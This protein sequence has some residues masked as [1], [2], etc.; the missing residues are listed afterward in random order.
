AQLNRI[1]DLAEEGLHRRGFGEEPLL[2]PLRR[3]ADALS[4]PALEQLNRLEHGE[5][6][7]QIAEDYGAL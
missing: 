4:N 1:L 5:T 3:R 7:D 2:E 6:I